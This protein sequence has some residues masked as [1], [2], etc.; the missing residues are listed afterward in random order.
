MDDYPQLSEL[1][2]D[3]AMTPALMRLR[4][5]YAERINSAVSRDAEATA[6]ELAATFETDVV[7]AVVRWLRRPQTAT[8]S[9]VSR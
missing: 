3:R 4:A 1:E 2:L 8:D 5:A 9:G 6:R 7:D